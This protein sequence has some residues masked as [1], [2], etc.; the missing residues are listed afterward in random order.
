VRRPSFA[1][2]NGNRLKHGKSSLTEPCSVW[3]VT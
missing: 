1:W 2:R 3:H